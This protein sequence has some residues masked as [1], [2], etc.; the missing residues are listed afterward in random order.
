V[1]A[2]HR[3]GEMHLARLPDTVS[4]APHFI[5]GDRIGSVL[6]PEI[7][8]CWHRENRWPKGLKK[9]KAQ[10][11]STGSNVRSAAPVFY[12]IRC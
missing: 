11:R 9:L 1:S 7:T 8:I 3:W 2:D 10:I 6:V 4:D 5:V 12:V